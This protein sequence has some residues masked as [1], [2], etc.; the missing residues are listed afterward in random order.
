M[1][2]VGER[3]QEDGVPEQPVDVADGEEGHGHALPAHRSPRA[4]V[5]AGHEEPDHHH[6]EGRPRAIGAH[7]GQRDEG[8]PDQP[9]VAQDGDTRPREHARELPVREHAHG[10]D[11][12]R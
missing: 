1:E 4:P 5:E 9:R 12:E 11:Q 2:A 10:H 8:A 3:A 6:R 7:E